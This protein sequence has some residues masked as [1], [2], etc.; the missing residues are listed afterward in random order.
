MEWLIRLRPIFVAAFFGALVLIG[1]AAYL[2]S[3]LLFGSACVGAHVAL[4]LFTTT[5]A[6][7]RVARE[8]SKP[9]RVMARVFFSM[10]AMLVVGWLVSAAV[11]M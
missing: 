7:G 4:F 1:V 9:A 10:Y 6:F 5:E 3:M 11:T 2:D 8:R